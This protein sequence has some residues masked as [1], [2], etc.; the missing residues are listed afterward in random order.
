MLLY[1]K[2]GTFNKNGFSSTNNGLFCQNSMQE[3]HNRENFSKYKD[4]ER[5]YPLMSRD[6]GPVFVHIAKPSRNTP[7]E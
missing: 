6:A 3:T 2:N 1:L 4:R 7:R 5:L